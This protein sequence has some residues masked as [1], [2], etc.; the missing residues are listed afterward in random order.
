MLRKIESMV[1]KDPPLGQEV[2]VWRQLIAGG[3]AIFAQTALVTGGVFGQKELDAVEAFFQLAVELN[4]EV[5]NP[6]TRE[7]LEL[8]GEYMGLMGQRLV[9]MGGKIDVNRWRVLGLL[10]DIGRTF[11]HRKGRNEVIAEVLM[12]LIGF[13]DDFMADFCPDEIFCPKLR[14]G[15]PE[16]VNLLIARGVELFV[17]GND[18]RGFELVADL[19]AKKVG[20][21][22]RRWGDVLT[23][24]HF[25][26]KYTENPVMFP[27]EERRWRGARMKGHTE[28]TNTLYVN[29]GQ[30][31]ERQL[32]CSLDEIVSQM[33][34]QLD[35]VIV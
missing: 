1:G 26:G 9:E 30:W 11:T 12:S 13:T 22:L 20:G 28:A 16:E 27:S 24:G 2:K 10:H 29:L 32:G 21:R 6:G 17:E 25:S 8:S 31:A 14:N 35:G 18:A 5:F 33:E 4:P 15:S 34:K 23:Q 19:L 3:R 7:H